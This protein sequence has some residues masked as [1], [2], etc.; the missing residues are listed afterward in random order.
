MDANERVSWYPE[1]RN[2]TFD[3]ACKL[4][5]GIDNGSETALGHYFETWCEGLFSIPLDVPWTKFG[6]A[7]KCRDL[8]LAEL[9]NIIRD[10]QGAAPGGSDA[11][12]LLICVAMMRGIL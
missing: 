1:L 6:K 12:G 5:V 8:L 3:V 4:L 9:E 7:K 2:Y 10:R 11:L